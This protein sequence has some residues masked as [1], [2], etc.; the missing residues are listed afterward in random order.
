MGMNNAPG[1]IERDPKTSR[2]DITE[3][4]EAIMA[5]AS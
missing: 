2:R 1:K 4:V 3:L 5:C